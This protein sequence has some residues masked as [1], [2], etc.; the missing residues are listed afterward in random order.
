[1]ELRLIEKMAML[2]AFASVANADDN[3]NDPEI[4]LLTNI[5]G[6]MELDQEK[7]NEAFALRPDEAG[8]VISN[9]E[10]EKKQLFYELMKETVFADNEANQKEVD[11][12]NNI[13]KATGIIVE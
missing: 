2:K 4:Q 1:M 3:L 13:L 10:P 12:A 6:N 11:Y 9:M 5:A 7:V 8:Y